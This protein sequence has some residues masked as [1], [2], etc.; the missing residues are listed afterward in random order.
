MKKVLLTVLAA[1]T[2]AC[3]FA[4]PKAFY[5]KKG[6]SYTRYNFGVASDLKFLDNGS[7]LS[8]TGYDQ[9]IDL[10]DIDYITFNA[11]V[12]QSLTE[13]Q[14]KQKLI[15]VAKELNTYIDVDGNAD[16]LK[17]VYTFFEDVKSPNGAYIPAPYGF[18]MDPAYYKIKPLAKSVLRNLGEAVKGDY[19]AM[20]NLAANAVK[21]YKMSKYYGVYTGNTLTECWDR[22]AAA[23]RIEFRYLSADGTTCYSVTLTPSA[24]DT[25]WTTS[26]AAVVLPNTIDVKFCLG[27]RELA[28][29]TIS[30][31]AEQDKILTMGIELKSNNVVGRN[32]LTITDSK[33]SDAATVSVGGRQLLKVDA[34]VNGIG[35][36]N[37]DNLKADWEVMQDKEIYDGNGNWVDYKEGDSRPFLSHFTYGESEADV[38]GKL[39]LHGKIGGLLK[40]YDRLDVDDSDAVY[41]PT[42]EY[43]GYYYY[44]GLSNIVSHSDNYSVVTCAYDSPEDYEDEAAALNDY[45]DVSFSYDGEKE[46]RG[47]LNFDVTES[48]SYTWNEEGYQ[49]YALVG[50]QLTHVSEG[51]DGNKPCWYYERATSLNEY[52]ELDGNTI[53]KVYVDEK[54]V[55]RP[56]ITVLEYGTNP[57]LTFPDG[58]SFMLGD[59]F[60]EDSFKVVVDDYHSIIDAFDAIVAPIEYLDSN[61]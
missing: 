41:S 45:S 48:D 29:S 21:L 26:D 11:P 16:V 7:R 55:L 51:Y 30:F 37:Y 17:M 57:V 47:Y 39:Q 9:V 32:T 20:R 14:N 53:E 49:T 43:G 58:T 4:L 1:A 59:F 13:S 19:P 35:L 56:V 46:I 36:L 50:G 33:I 27:S 24:G 23:D 6:D 40:L 34:Y 52:G 54:D 25:Q 22:T 31:T 5:V 61:Y 44:K 28:H 42:F 38:L 12:K 15:D 3:A 10:T 60:T 18:Y 8:V 2:V